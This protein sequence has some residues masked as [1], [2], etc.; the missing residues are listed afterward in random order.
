MSF[1]LRPRWTF[2]SYFAVQRLR[3]AVWRAARLEGRSNNGFASATSEHRDAV[4]IAPA[5]Y[6]DL[7]GNYLA[8]HARRTAVVF[9]AALVRARDRYNRRLQRRDE[10]VSHVEQAKARCAADDSASTL[11]AQLL[12]GLSI[13]ISIP[14][15]WGFVEKF[16][17]PLVFS[18]LACA[19]LSLIDAAVAHLAG[20]LVAILDLDQPQTPFALMRKQRVSRTVWLGLVA[21]VAVLLIVVFAIFRSTNGGPVWLW[22]AVG[23][24][25]LLI[26]A[27]AGFVGYPASRVRILNRMRGRLA[28]AERRLLRARSRLELVVRWMAG[29]VET[30]R[31]RLLDLDN[32]GGSAF[33]RA[34]RRHHPPDSLP[35]SVPDPE[36]ISEEE[37]LR[38][39]FSPL[40]EAD[41]EELLA[42]QSS[43]GQ[44][45]RR[46][47]RP[48]LRSLPAGP[49]TNGSCTS[50]TRRT[51]SP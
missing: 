6:Q 38:Q 50:T 5:P 30:L 14:L 48:A 33:R 15:T 51:G 21:A 36:F 26:A 39:L 46:A 1:L 12:L 45:A 13:L 9:N 24:A 34:Y 18:A 20:R 27:W 2:F 4:E 7:L 41:V 17:W 40:G 35:P 11:G 16:E 3:F 47:G 10:L 8:Q 43:L 23:L 22:L 42:G 29:S 44:P 31:H 28:R 49:M 25:A 37:V 32:R 19:G